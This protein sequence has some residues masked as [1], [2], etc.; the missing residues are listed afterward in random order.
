MNSLAVL[1][2][3]IIV[4]YISNQYANHIYGKDKEFVVVE[5]IPLPTT[6]NDF[7]RNQN[8]TGSY[9]E[10]FGKSGEELNLINSTVEIKNVNNNENKVFV[11]QRFFVN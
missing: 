11:P 8:L 1:S 9:S 4:I 6:Y 7:F 5:E 3:F 10:M 2:L